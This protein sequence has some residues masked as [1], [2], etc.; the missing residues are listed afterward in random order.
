MCVH[1]KSF[2]FG[3]SI[4]MYAALYAG[5]GAFFIISTMETV[6]PQFEIKSINKS[7]DFKFD[8]HTKLDIQDKW[9]KNPGFDYLAIFSCMSTNRDR[10]ASNRDLVLINYDNV[11]CTIS[12]CIISAVS[13]FHGAIIDVRICQVWNVL[14]HY[15]SF[16]PW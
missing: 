13:N 5:S 16:N 10:G 11:F 15:R 6:Q 14:F 9:K 12:I 1:L 4:S 7:R 8:N 2:F 3:N